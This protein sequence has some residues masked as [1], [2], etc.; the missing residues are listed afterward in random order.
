MFNSYPDLFPNVK[1]VP[2]A[3]DELGK[4]ISLLHLHDSLL[5]AVCEYSL[6]VLLSLAYTLFP[7]EVG[8]LVSLERPSNYSNVPLNDEYKR[9]RGKGI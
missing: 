8:D 3:H 2:L 5:L 7:L 4:L 9:E 6:L 1:S